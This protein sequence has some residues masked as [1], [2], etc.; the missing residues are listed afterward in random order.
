MDIPFERVGIVGVGLIG[1]SLGLA[2]KQDAPKTRVIGFGRTDSRLELARGL[3]AIDEY[4]TGL[5]ELRQCDLIIL[6]TPVENIAGMFGKIGGHLAC[7]AVVTDVGSTKR[8]ICEQAWSTLPARVEFI[9]GHPVAGR[10]VAGVEHILPGLFR[11]APYVLCSRGGA[12]SRNFGRMRKVLE[13]LGA[14]LFRMTP[15]EHDRAISRLSHLPQIL[16]TALASVLGDQMTGIAGSGLRDMLRLAGSPYSIWQGI[17]ESNRD[18]I[19]NA[20][21]EFIR[22]LVQVRRLLRDGDLAAEFARA[23]EVHQKIRKTGNTGDVSSSSRPSD[24]AG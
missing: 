1:G 21:G 11:D 22:H 13:L 17:F 4:S 10:E 2:L 23:I 24:P 16:S 3:G 8:V 12:E 7:D 9:G 20:L 14:R 15:E 18:N 19:D 5:E 6:A